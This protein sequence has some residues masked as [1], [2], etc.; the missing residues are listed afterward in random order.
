MK[1]KVPDIEKARVAFFEKWKKISLLGEV[2]NLLSWDQEINMTGGEASE[3][4]EQMALMAELLHKSLTDPDFEEQVQCLLH[5]GR[6][7][8]LDELTFASL[9]EAEYIIRC[10]RALPTKLVAALAKH[11]SRSLDVWQVARKEND[12]KTFAPYLKTMVELTR[13]KA[14]ALVA[15]GIGKTRYESLLFEFE[16]DF[17]LAEVDEMFNILKSEL[18]PLV[19]TVLES[20]NQVDNSFLFAAYPIDAQERICRKIVTAI[21]FDWKMGRMDTSVHPFT[22]NVAS[23][24]ARIT[25]RYSV[26]NLLEALYGAIHE[27]GHAL[28]DQGILREWALTPIGVAGGMALHESQSRFWEVCI[29]RSIDFSYW[30]REIL[31]KEFSDQLKS[32]SRDDFYRAVNKA[33]IH[34]IRCDSD[35]LTYNLHILLRYEMEKSMFS[36]ELSVAEAPE[37]WNQRF[38]EFF[39]CKPPTDKEGILQDVHWACGLFGYFPSYTIGNIIAEELYGAMQKELTEKYMAKRIRCGD[40]S[41][42][43]EWLR[44]RVHI[45]GR[46][47]G[48]KFIVEKAIGKPISA[49]YFLERIKSKYQKIY[50]F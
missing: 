34:Y 4:G 2:S 46:S 5:H 35:P 19:N 45:H 39:R 7:G 17:T 41:Y 37:A 43:L 25:N 49:T 29:G 24:T 40:F 36:G 13:E 11:G 21:G 27:A 42:I 20:V 22:T 18:P 12:W 16:R 38:E 44:S 48:T 9:S 10:E 33:G 3:R 14:D 31:N 23:A 47:N 28:Y 26:H 8:L 50:Q 32:T 15:V 1:H 6:G 30:C